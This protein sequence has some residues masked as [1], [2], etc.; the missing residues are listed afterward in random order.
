L[1]SKEHYLEVYP[2]MLALPTDG[3][4][5]TGGYAPVFVKDWLEDRVQT[6]KIIFLSGRFL[7][8]PEYQKELEKKVLTQ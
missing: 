5:T 1:T 4:F 7:P 6:G 8:S 2:A 3:E